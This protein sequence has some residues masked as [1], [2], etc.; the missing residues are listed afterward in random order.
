MY[1]GGSKLGG[2]GGGGGRGVAATGVNNKRSSFPPPPP[3]APTRPTSTTGRLSRGGG[4]SNLRNRP[5]TTSNAAT[6]SSAAAVEETFS[7]IPGSSPPAFAMI[8]RLVP[9]L[10]EEIRRAEAHSGNA[11][12]KFDS[13][14]T[15]PTGNVIDV[16]GKEFRFTWSKEFGDLC[17]IYEERQGGEG[18]NGLL[19][20]SGCAWRKSNVQ[21]I[22]DESTTNHV[23]MRSE[24]A[25][26][27]QKARKAIV[28]DHG[29]P[30]MKSQLKQMAAAETNPWR[31]FKKKEPPFKKR[32]VDP[33][34]VGGPPKTTFRPGLVSTANAKGRHSSSPLPSP[35]EQFGTPASPLASTHMKS[36]EGAPNSEKETP[37]KA[38]SAV[39][40]TP[41]HK[42]HSGAK[43][44]D[45]Q[46]MLIALLTDNPKGLNLKAL[47]KAV[48]DTFPNSAKKIEPIIEKIA[49]F[50]DPGRY[51]L[52]A[53]VE[54]ESLK[55]PM[56]ESGSSPEDNH[57]QTQASEDNHD[58][59]NAPETR[60]EEKHPAVILQ[61][62]AQ[63]KSIVKESNVLEKNDILHQSADLFGEKKVSDNSEGQAGSSSESGSDS[64]SDS[65]SSDSGS[66]SGSPVESAS[67]SSSDSESDAS[68]NSKEGS[69][70]D[71]D[72]ISDDDKE[73][74]HKLQV[75]KPHFSTSPDPW[76][77]VRN[78][79][80]KKQDVDGSA[81]IHIGGH[82]SPVVDIEGGHENDAVDIE[83]DFGDGEKE[84]E[85]AANDGLDPSRYGKKHIEEAKSHSSDYDLILQRQT[86]IGNLF[87][88]NEDMGGDRRREQCDSSENMFKGKSKRGPGVNSFGEKPQRT[89]KVKAER[90]C[91]RD[92]NIEDTSKVPTIPGLYR[93]DREGSAGLSTEKGYN[94][95]IPGKSGSD[96]QQPGQRSSEQQS[97]W[98]KAP[99]TAGRS[100]HAESSGYSRKSLEKNAQV[101]EAFSIRK[102]KP[103]RNNHNE[104]NNSK[105]KKVPRNS[106]EGGVGDRYPAPSDSH[107]WKQSE[108][109]GKFKDITQI[110]RPRKNS[111]PKDSDRVDMD[112]NLPASRKVL[113]RELSELELGELRESVPEET[114]VKGQSERKG[115]FKQL[116][117]NPSSSDHGNSDLSKGKP[118]EKET[119]ESR[120]PTPPN[121]SAGDKGTPEHFE[122]SSRS[123]HKAV[124]SQ[125]QHLPRVDNSEVGPQS[126]KLADVSSRSRH[127]E[128]ATKL[129]NGMEGSGE[130]HK[131]APV[132]I[133][134]VHDFKHELLSQH[135]KES[136]MQTSNTNSELMNG[137]K[138]NLMTKGK[139]NTRKRRESS[140]EEGSSSYS[141]YE[142]DVPELKGP[143]KD[144]SQYK[145]Y[146]QEY[147]DKY[148]DYLS[149]NKILEGYRNEFDKLGKDL[150]SAKGR[151][152]DRYQKILVQ[153]RE[154][155]RRCA[156]R[157][158]R[159]KKIF[160]MLHQELANLK[161][162]IK[163]FAQSYTKD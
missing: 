17:D 154:S 123:H 55:K 54:L 58:Q 20:E 102:E 127:N 93:A 25:E 7:L 159:L 152:M 108:N 101:H 42:G 99:D 147:R 148:D 131:K 95:G 150:E 153:L 79:G 13:I 113:Q 110:S 137:R 146:V 41:V 77:S 35:P 4:S 144:F 72:I 134:Q 139:N 120:K 78:G 86:F 47:E 157:H 23:K 32:K 50:Q 75:S 6:S 163:D 80:E 51:V 87:D 44:G 12:I 70:E 128:H 30:S 71:V 62:E 64:D 56:S 117:N 155:Y 52:K 10:V 145:E 84:S 8:I 27:K 118:V 73:P 132:S 121:L 136:K 105:E 92:R 61:E 36:K 22:L 33:P 112:K 16:G 26:R 130:R 107:N 18:G 115:S 94:K 1:G 100:N 141:K 83:K 90:L 135:T 57:Q 151:D 116:E 114:P 149:L 104:D 103:P 60:F 129:G 142:K 91:P 63:L 161:Q 31:T 48:G 40:E 46:S 82:G 119:L 140:S 45:L 143:I 98:A 66:D 9:D 2:R 24:E 67:G 133:Q 74:Q 38:A 49:T 76:T 89:K 96:L 39:W 97:A 160:V 34:H 81:A 109:S 124:Q 158:K 14:A 53:G 43:P 68:S 21:R 5:G 3:P 28:L 111:S 125:Q 59:R 29:N 122:D 11:R 69:D 138:D 162:R 85:I 88:D 37:T 106:K 126:S 19:V 65:D 156:T 15:N